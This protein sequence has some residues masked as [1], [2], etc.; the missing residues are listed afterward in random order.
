VVNTWPP[1]PLLPTTAPSRSA[2]EHI[3]VPLGTGTG[4]GDDSGSGVKS[5][6]DGSHGTA[7]ATGDVAAG[8]SIPTQALMNATI[9][10]DIATARMTMNTL[11]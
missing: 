6:G 5:G 4:C 7:S 3:G 10:I 11:R 1:A 2:A 9:A 8:E